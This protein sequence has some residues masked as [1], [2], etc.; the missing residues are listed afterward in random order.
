MQL[1]LVNFYVEPL[2]NNFRSEEE[3]RDIFE[4]TVCIRKIVAGSRDEL[5][6]IATDEDKR[7]F[8][9]EYKAF[10]EAGGEI[11]SGTPLSQWPA[12]GASF[13]K[14]M[15]YFNVKT[16]EQLADLADGRAQAMGMGI[17]EKAVAARAWL[18][19]TQ[20]TGAQIGKI[21]VENERLKDELEGMREQ[22]KALMAAQNE[23]APK[24]PLKKTADATA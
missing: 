5:V 23:M 9:K 11:V 10:I 12:A 19:A 13:C 1:L 7:E 6:R 3:G 24:M 4:D 17:N 2:R 14:E 20:G 15:A 18:E 8:S 21:A 16:V 22:L